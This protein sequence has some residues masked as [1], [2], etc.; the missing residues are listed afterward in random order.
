MLRS[1]GIWDRHLPA[2][3]SP[4]QTISEAVLAVWNWPNVLSLIHIS[5]VGSDFKDGNAWICSSGAKNKFYNTVGEGRKL[6]VNP[7]K[8]GKSDPL[9]QT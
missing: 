1:Y 8:S 6:N 3:S 4:P 2:D 5:R 9:V 7:S